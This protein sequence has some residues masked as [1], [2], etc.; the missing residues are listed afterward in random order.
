MDLPQTRKSTT[1][2]AIRKAISLTHARW[3]SEDQSD[4]GIAALCCAGCEVLRCPPA[5]VLPR[6][7]D[8][9]LGLSPYTNHF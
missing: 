4:R 3:T 6:V 9:D 1:P 8:A 5:N 2:A 7:G